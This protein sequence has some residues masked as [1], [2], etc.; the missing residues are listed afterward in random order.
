MAILFSRLHEGRR[1]EVRSAGQTRRLYTDGVFHTQ[2]HPARRLSGSV[3][4]LLALPALVLP[5]VRR[6]LLLGV[7]GGAVVHVLRTFVQP[8]QM[9]GVDLSPM[10][11]QLARR[12]FDLAGPDLEL[13]C[14]DARAFVRDY[15]GDAFDL[16]IE[17]LFGGSHG[18][19]ERAIVADR[20]WCEALGRL[21]AGDGALVINTLSRQEVRAT[22]F[23][24]D[25]QVR[26][27]WATCLGLSVPGYTN[28]VGAFF[29]K[30]VTPAALRKAVRA[31]EWRLRQEKNGLLRYRIQRLP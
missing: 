6:V 4:D 26:Q 12:Y 1:Y 7:G 13:H 15:R 21:V 30:P 22:A 2:Y 9:V 5:S 20:A 10:H 23:V 3:W 28:T 29:R 18:R 27:E 19:P 25:P 24:A 8:Q 31:D 11:L 16:V 14:A 17:D